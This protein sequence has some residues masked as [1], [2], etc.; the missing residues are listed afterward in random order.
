MNRPLTLIFGTALWLHPLLA[1]QPPARE[2][3]DTNPLPLL[4]VSADGRYLTNAAG[5]PVFLFG[6]TAWGLATRLTNEEV[7]QYLEDRRKKGI[8]ALGVQ[9]TTGWVDKDLPSAGR[10]LAGQRPFLDNDPTRFNE[11]YFAHL[12]WC[13]TEATKRG[14]FI[15]LK[16]GE[17]IKRRRVSE[18][19]TERKTAYAFG[20]H[21][22]HRL[23]KFND[24]MVW[25]V[26]FDEFPH[27]ADV[28]LYDAFAEGLADGVTGEN[29]HDGRAAHD[30]LLMTFHPPAGQSSSPTFHDRPWLDFNSVQT[31]RHTDSTC[32]LLRR[33]YAKNP[34]KP[35][36]MVEPSYEN[37]RHNDNGAAVWV[38]RQAC[39]SVLAGSCGFVYGN[40]PMWSFGYQSG[41]DG[42]TDWKRWLD[43]PG[44]VQ[45][46][47]I[48]E[49]ILGKAWWT[50]RPADEALTEGTGSG[51]TRRVAARSADGRT[52][53]VYFPNPGQ[54]AIDLKRLT[55]N[56]AVA[57]WHR[58][59]DAST[60]PAGTFPTGKPA[61][62]ALP[63]GWEDGLLE[64]TPAD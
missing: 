61:R 30:R 16:T 22:G 34:V 58:T 53:R 47:R 48:Q 50:F 24:R 36:L 27:A 2:T 44:L 28:P 37:A 11:A 14:F 4:R 35:T 38:R 63:E 62:F 52:L 56:A 43:A 18:K 7:I 6:D 13:L 12:D 19:I 20:W 40:D 33:D 41:G 29:A 42:G 21:V 3:V 5:K 17:P 23:G 54:A 10:N 26:G 15:L 51:D 32:T 49:K 55:G 9:L 25:M 60:R 8:N 39:W 31:Y 64:I 1:C 57:T 59:T 45:T 46:L